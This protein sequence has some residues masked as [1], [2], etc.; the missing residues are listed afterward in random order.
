LISWL[1][2]YASSE[3]LS[4][5]QLDCGVQRHDA[6]RFYFAQGMR[7]GAYRFELPIVG[8]AGPRTSDSRHGREMEAE[9]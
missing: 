2:D 4:A 7:I 3:H 5:I 9:T 6:H 8:P 1:A